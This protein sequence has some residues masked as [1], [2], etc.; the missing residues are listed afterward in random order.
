MEHFEFT[1][2]KFTFRVAAGRAYTAD[3]LWVL[4]EGGRVRVGVTDFLQQNSGDVAFA[5]MVEPGT[6]VAAGERLANVET[7]KVDV[8]LPSPVSGTV[9][10]VNEK[11]QLEA[12]IINQDPYGEGWLALIEPAAWPV[13]RA[14]LM[15]AEAYYA[16]SHARAL[17]EIG[18]S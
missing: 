17:E 6:V 14:A 4:E 1:V 13:E 2:D 18:R 8:A 16:H 3:G 10:A 12:E 5:E 15:T 7:I 11:L 9:V